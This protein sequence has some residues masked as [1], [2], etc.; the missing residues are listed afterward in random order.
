MSL[1][2]EHSPGQEELNLSVNYVANGLYLILARDGRNVL[3]K[4][5]FTVA[6]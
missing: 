6:K 2:I 3:G 5:R 4:G 1:P